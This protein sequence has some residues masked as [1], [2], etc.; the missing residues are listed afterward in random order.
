MSPNDKPPK[1]PLSRTRSS[2]LPRPNRFARHAGPALRSAARKRAPSAT[3]SQSYNRCI[4]EAVAAATR[5][6]AA[7]K[8]PL[9]MST[10]P[11][12]AGLTAEGGQTTLPASTR[13]SGSAANTSEDVS[14]MEQE[15]S[16]L[17][18][19][20]QTVCEEVY[21]RKTR[22]DVDDV[23]SQINDLRVQVERL[24]RHL[25]SPHASQRSKVEDMPAE[26]VDPEDTAPSHD[27]IV[28]QH[29]LE[30]RKLQAAVRHLK[31]TQGRRGCTGAR[32]RSN[33]S[34]QDLRRHKEE[35]LNA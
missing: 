34:R 7:Q 12:P 15:K 19:P 8:P 3:L 25:G 9:P 33:I 2:A 6:A 14:K 28:K 27:N 31:S 35:P 16:A 23:K 24:S 32:G 5:E 29:K 30:I 21:T 17:L 10:S 18:P 20:V 11:Q 26:P 1:Q 13:Q 4:A 22:E